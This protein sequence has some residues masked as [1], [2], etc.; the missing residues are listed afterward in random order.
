MRHVEE[1]IG[2][3]SVYS[4]VAPTRIPPPPPCILRHTPLHSVFVKTDFHTS[5]PLPAKGCPAK[6]HDGGVPTQVSARRTTA[7]AANAKAGLTRRRH[8]PPYLNDRPQIR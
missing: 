8:I 6:S 3:F 1:T 2:E 7:A 5:L 4:A